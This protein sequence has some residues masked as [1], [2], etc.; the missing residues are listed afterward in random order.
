VTLVLIVRLQLHKAWV[1]ALLFQLT[2]SPSVHTWY[3]TVSS[4]DALA[5]LLA[6]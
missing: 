3:L 2:W 6:G 5:L 4:A 1:T